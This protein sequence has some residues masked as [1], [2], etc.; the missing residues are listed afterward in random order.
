MQKR[1]CSLHRTF[2][3]PRLEYARLSAMRDR[4]AGPFLV[5]H[6]LAANSSMSLQR[7]DCLLR[8]CTTH[9]NDNMVAFPFHRKLATSVFFYAQ[10]FGEGRRKREEGHKGVI[11][12][13]GNV[14]VRRKGMWMG[15]FMGH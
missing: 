8:S 11:G 4:R 5:L 1:A 14:C 13:D 7:A 12:G 15:Q 2:I 3:K 9:F 6:R 10:H